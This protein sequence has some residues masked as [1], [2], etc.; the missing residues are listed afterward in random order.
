[1]NRVF[2]VMTVGLIAA[3]GS[4]CMSKAESDCRTIC[5]AGVADGCRASGTNCDTVCATATD[6]YK[7]ASDFLTGSSCESE[8]DLLYTCKV[9][10]NVCALSPCTSEAISFT[11]CLILLDCAGDQA[12]PDGKV[13]AGSAMTNIMAW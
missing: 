11:A 3:L 6:D 2:L 1:M 4:G 9:D 5:E 7:T 10:A 8:F 13:E 12:C